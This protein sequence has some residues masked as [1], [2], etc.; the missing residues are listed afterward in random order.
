MT[1]AQM[2]NTILD[3]QRQLKALASRP[4]TQ[5]SEE[6]KAEAVKAQDEFQIVNEEVI[7]TSVSIADFMEE[8]YLS[9]MGLEKGDLNG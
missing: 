4:Y 8:Y 9:Q 7:E 6:A 5:R 3:L 2:E 1:K